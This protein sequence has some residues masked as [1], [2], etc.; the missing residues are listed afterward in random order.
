MDEKGTNIERDGRGSERDA[1]SG[2]LGTNL[3]ICTKRKFL[4]STGTG[5]EE[6]LQTGDGSEDTT[7]ALSVGRRSSLM[8]R[9]SNT[10]GVGNSHAKHVSDSLA[11]KPVRSKTTNDSLRLELALHQCRGSKKG[12]SLNC[13]DAAIA[14]NPNLEDALVNF[15]NVSL[16][17]VT[18]TWEFKD[19]AFKFFTPGWFEAAK[20]EKKHFVSRWCIKMEVQQE[21]GFSL[22]ENVDLCRACVEVIYCF[23]AGTFDA[24]AEKLKNGTQPGASASYAIHAPRANSAAN[25]SRA[26][27]AS[28]FHGKLLAVDRRPNLAPHDKYPSSWDKDTVELIIDELTECFAHTDDEKLFAAMLAITPGSYV[29]CVAWLLHYVQ[30]NAESWPNKCL[31]QLPE[32]R[33]DLNVCHYNFPHSLFLL[34]NM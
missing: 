17:P 26:E 13:I 8:N 29:P 4:P 21:G 20:T 28:L 19:W 22:S 34:H 7:G 11:L 15:R 2:I 10:V 25:L 9:R 33:V 5:Y 27:A 23:G 32:V 18:D 31:Y 6:P 12:A 24:V 16:P 14:G 3:G 1:Y 30:N